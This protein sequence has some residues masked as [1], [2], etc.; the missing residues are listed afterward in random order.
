MLS[1]ALEWASI[2]IGAQL[3]GSMEGRPFLRAF[4]IKIYIRIN[5][6]IPC[7]RLSLSIG[8]PLGEPVGNSLAETF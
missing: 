6:K 5:V 2:F 7:K 3:L 4:E 1:K 8:A